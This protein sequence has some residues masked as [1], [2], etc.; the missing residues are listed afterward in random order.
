MQTPIVRLLLLSTLV[1]SLALAQP[2]SVQ[3]RLDRRAETSALVQQVLEGRM[4]VPSAISRLRMLREEPFAAQ[5]LLQGL[6]TMVDVRRMRDVTAVLAGLETRTAEPSLAQL[7]HHEDG[8]VRMY[9]AQGLGRLGSQR[10]DVLLPLLEDK[11]YGVRR[12]TARALGASRVPRVGKTLVTLARTETDPQTRVMMLE[13]VGGAGDKKQVP[14]LKAFL[15]DSSESARFASARAL[16]LLGAPEGFAF[17]RKLLASEDRLVR[18][19]G[20]GLYEGLPVKQTGTTL[21]PLLEDKD[22]PLAAGAARILA[23]GG[24]K[25]MVSWLVLASWNA[26]GEEKLTYEKELETLQLADDERKALLR[27]AGVAP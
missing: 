26:H 13:A 4:A 19:Q 7:T 24:D 18:R 22:R 12:E 10:V 23:Q 9:A 16:C 20:L 21:R 8:A 1:S 2:P 27:A 5:R 3:K 14:A 15:D 25:A 17:A 11:S 6:S